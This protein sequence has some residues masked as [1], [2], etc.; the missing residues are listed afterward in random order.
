MNQQQIA[1]TLAALALAV[2]VFG[3]ALSAFEER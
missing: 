2:A 3:L 1:I